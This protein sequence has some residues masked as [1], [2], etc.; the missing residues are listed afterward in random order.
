MKA[1]IHGEHA[2]PILEEDGGDYL[3]AS[4]QTD[5]S[6]D[7]DEQDPSQTTKA[8][9]SSS[10]L[11]TKRFSESHF[12]QRALVSLISKKVLRAFSLAGILNSR[13]LSL[14][15]KTSRLTIFRAKWMPYLAP[16]RTPAL[17]F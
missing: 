7:K 9:A 10:L 13:R 1:P 6:S 15:K 3:D 11:L 2:F 16:F 17:K 4:F 12:P 8:F 14:L 5:V